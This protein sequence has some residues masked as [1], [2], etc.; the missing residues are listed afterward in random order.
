MMKLMLKVLDAK[1]DFKLLEYPFH[2]KVICK[3]PQRETNLWV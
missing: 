1:D 3:V 2:N